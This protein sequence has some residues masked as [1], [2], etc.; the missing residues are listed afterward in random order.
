VDKLADIFKATI[1]VFHGIISTWLFLEFSEIT[2]DQFQFLILLVFFTV[3]NVMVWSIA[4]RRYYRM[5]GVASSVALATDNI[6]ALHYRALDV[7]GLTVIAICA[8]LLAA[9]IQRHDLIL[10][11][12]NS[13][14]NWERNFSDAPFS[15]VLS[16]IISG[17]ISEIDARGPRTVAAAKNMAYLRVYLK[18]QKIAFEGYPRVAPGKRDL[19]EFFLSPACTYSFATDDSTKVNSVQEV[20]GPGVL[21]RVV[22]SAAIEVIDAAKSKC[23]KLHD[24]SEAAMPVRGPSTP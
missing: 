19:R 17:R 14:T 15:I 11:A 21:L 4:M 1:A 8:G 9:Y 18:D 5:R 20:E 7:I 10:R 16:K 2:V 22:E 24:V 13:V 23:A 12:A 3:G 6:S